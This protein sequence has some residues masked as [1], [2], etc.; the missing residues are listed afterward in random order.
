MLESERE[1]GD[2]SDEAETLRVSSIFAS[3][4]GLETNWQKE[5]PGTVGVQVQL[6][7]TS[8]WRD[9]KTATDAASGDSSV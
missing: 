4:V 9:G 3:K 1:C 2:Q 5:R 7:R 8:T 6:L